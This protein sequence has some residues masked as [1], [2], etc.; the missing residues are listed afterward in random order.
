MRHEQK[1]YKEQT[2]FGKGGWTGMRIL[3]FKMEFLKVEV[4]YLRKF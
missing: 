2:Y 4:K 3:R 1:G